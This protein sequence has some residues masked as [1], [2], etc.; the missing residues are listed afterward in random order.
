MVH[1]SSHR[2]IHTHIQIIKRNILKDGEAENWESSKTQGRQH[3]MMGTASGCSSHSLTLGSRTGGNASICL[4]PHL[5][6]I[7]WLDLTL[8]GTQRLGLWVSLAVGTKTEMSL[9]PFTTLLGL[10]P[11]DCRELLHRNDGSQYEAN[12]REMSP[13]EVQVCTCSENN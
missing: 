11:V 2:N 13:V 5:C 1:I 12:M 8:T 7:L 9:H 6:T 10:F 3:H 4:W